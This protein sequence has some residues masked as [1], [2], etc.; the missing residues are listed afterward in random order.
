MRRG[1]LVW[2]SSDPPFVFCGCCSASIMKN[3]ADRKTVF[4]LRR[5]SKY[6]TLPRCDLIDAF[7]S[8]FIHFKR[9]S[10]RVVILLSTSANDTFG[11]EDVCWIASTCWLLREA[12]TRIMKL[13]ASRSPQGE[14]KASGAQSWRETHSGCL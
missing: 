8:Y 5:F 14:S 9:P 3:S 10:E 6:Y 11:M 13:R 7:M 1:T 4:P 2:P 12:G